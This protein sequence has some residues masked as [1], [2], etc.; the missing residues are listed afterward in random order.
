ML[1]EKQKR[2]IFIIGFSL[3]TI[4][5]GYA[6]F[7]VFFSD[8]PLIAPV[9]PGTEDLTDDGPA[10]PVA[11][12]GDPIGSIPD[13]GDTTLPISPDITPDTEEGTPSLRG[14]TVSPQLSQ[15][16]IN[17]IEGFNVNSNGQVQFY[18]TSEQKFYKTLANG[19]IKE[20][21]E[22]IFY[23]VEQVNWS[24]TTDE[25]ILE[26]P[27]GSNIYYN[28]ETKK[29]VTLPQHW[30]EFSF[31]KTGSK[32]AAKSVGYS[33]DNQWL[34]TADPTGKNVSLIEPMGDNADKVIVDWSPNNE[35]VALSLTGEA[36]GA[37]RQELLFVGLNGENYQ[38]TVVEGRGLVTEWDPDGQKLLYSVY[39]ERSELKPEL[40][41]V[42]AAPN[43]I[44]TNRKM[45]KLNTWADKCTFADE[46]YVYCGVPTELP[47]G[48]GLAP[49]LADSTADQIY[50]VDTVTN[51]K[52]IIDTEDYF[53]VET[54][55]Y[56][57]KN[58]Q[59]IFTDK[60]TEGLFTL[61]L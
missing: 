60:V 36:L 54:M 22:K 59:L 34:V 37:D 42:N 19:E 43:N 2:L 17:D 53:V 15:V 20:I 21:D 11:D 56:D 30:E 14:V 6:L 57:E 48:A 1:E 39:N 58:N 32:I 8:K 25:A 44:G 52:T 16:F 12:I 24:P 23:N 9:G 5:L 45:L 35:I 27:D 26:Y 29:Q 10:F 61:A 46:R 33:E 38:S 50:R 28:F 40:W 41:I 47:T 7:R 13:T 4:L 3:I 31:S 18:D 55:K 49:E 51:S